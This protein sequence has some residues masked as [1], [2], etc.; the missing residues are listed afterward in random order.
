MMRRRC[1]GL[2]ALALLSPDP[3][4]AVARCFKAFAEIWSTQAKV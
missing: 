4:D 1:G 3:G 2:Q